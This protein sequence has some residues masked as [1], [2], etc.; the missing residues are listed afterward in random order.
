[1]HLTSLDVNLLQMQFSAYKSVGIS[2]ATM[3]REEK[4]SFPCV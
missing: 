3:L 4:A 1:M 2:G